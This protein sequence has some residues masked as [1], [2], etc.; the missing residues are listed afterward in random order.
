MSKPTQLSSSDWARRYH[1]WSRFD[2]G[3]RMDKEAWFEVTPENV[4]RYVA[5]RCR[6]KV[7]V[8]DGCCG[9]GGNSVQFALEGMRVIGIDSNRQRLDYLMQNAS[10]Y[11]AASLITTVCSDLVQYLASIAPDDTSSSALY[12]SPPWGGKSCYNQHLVGLDDLPIKL[13]PILRQAFEKFGSFVVHLP[14]NID[15]DDIRRFVISLK[16]SYCELEAIYYSNPE[17]RLKCY[18]L[19]VDRTPSIERTVLGQYRD[20]SLIALLPFC[21][22]D[23]F[24]KYYANCLLSVNYIGRYVLRSMD[25]KRDSGISYTP[26]SH[27]IRHK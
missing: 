13:K 16:I 3:V 4:A 15:I 7:T 17:C 11:G 5:W 24:A 6:K 23:R 26:F 1:L 12:V 10:V 21:G 27:I 18:I 20:Q 8:Y 2:Y 25:M 14:R 9:V 22:N 19:F